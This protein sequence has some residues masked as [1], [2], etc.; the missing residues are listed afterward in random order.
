MARDF[1]VYES[2]SPRE[3]QSCFYRSLELDRMIEAEMPEI[4]AR[5]QQERA[6]LDAW[7]EA[8]RATY[9]PL[10]IEDLPA[11]QAPASGGLDVPVRSA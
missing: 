7:Y 10:P 9:T 3:Y 8:F 1:G 6:E 4:W 11:L 5:I 2:V